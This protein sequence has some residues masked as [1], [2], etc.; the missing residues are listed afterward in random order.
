V[1]LTFTPGPGAQA[2]ALSSAGRV[3][4]H[5]RQA[6]AAVGD[7]GGFWVM[8]KDG[9]AQLSGLMARI[10]GDKPISLE[11]DS[12][13]ARISALRGPDWPTAVRNWVAAGG[14][15]NV[16]RA[17]LTAGDALIGVNSGTL[18]VDNDGRLSGVLE[19]SLRQAPRALGAMGASGTIPQ[20]RAEAASALT[21]ARAGAGDLAQ[22]TLHFEAGQTTL[23]PVAIAQ[24][25][26][27]YE[28]R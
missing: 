26:K 18:G 20:E 17:G 13:L 28:A 4:V 27:V 15:A 1:G 8:V 5:V 25:P 10:A 23:G 11:W 7:E 9:H 3:E 22:V 14:K 24:A 21:A 16:K 2:F 12:R 6:P 19:L